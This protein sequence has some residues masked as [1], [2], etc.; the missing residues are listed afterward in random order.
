MVFRIPDDLATDPDS[1]TLR[2]GGFCCAE[3]HKTITQRPRNIFVSQHMLI[4]VKAG[5]KVF[6]FPHGE[7]TIT[8]GNAIFLRRGCYL[9]C[10]S[11][12]RGAEYE[13]L[14]VFFPEEEI[15]R[16]WLGLNFTGSKAAAPG[17][18]ADEPILSLPISPGLE[19]F[20]A[21]LTD[22][23]RSKSPFLEE[24]LRLKFQELLL[25][26]LDS[27]AGQRLRR[28]FDQLCAQSRRCPVEVAREHLLKP[29][30]LADYAALSGRSLS[31]FK[32]DFVVVAK[33][34]P[35]RWLQQKRLAHARLL[36]RRSDQSVAE[37]CLASGFENVS[38]FIRA[39]RGRFGKTP[40]ADRA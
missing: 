18:K 25:L 20:R 22:C 17:A 27:T 4:F 5:A 8:A 13:S 30:S 2:L 38:H 16:F 37:V 24:L 28:F 15:R 29:L 9:L 1:R 40:A 36:L 11:L 23:F 12:G 31:A 3:Y 6:R 14:S 21:A 39:Y 35:G 10:E 33:E 7:I 34:S 26:L 32:R 19:H